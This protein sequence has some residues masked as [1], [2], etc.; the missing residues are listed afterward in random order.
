MRNRRINLFRGMSIVFAIMA[1]WSL[2]SICLAA[3][4]TGKTL[5]YKYSGDV[6][7]ANRKSGVTVLDGHAWFR[8][9]DGD[10]LNADKITM[11]RDVE[12]NEIIRIESVGNVEMKEKGMESTCQQSVF[13]EA[14]GRI[15]LKG[16]V[17]APAII[18]DGE[19]R[20]EALFI[21]YY[22]KEDRIFAS[23][24]LFSVGMD[25]QSDLDNGA[26]SEGLRQDF[27]NNNISLSADATVS[28]EESGIGWSITDGGKTYVI[29]KEE[30]KLSI[31][32]SDGVKGHVKVAVKETEPTEEETEK[33]EE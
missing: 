3:N 9:S 7:T 31:F 32:A 6:V 26:I 30:D 10:Y 19:N 1:I 29:R 33:K 2:R 28:K 11:Y 14:E 12:T 17:G 20:I 18:D 13:Y 5:T 25:A 22:R 27:K 8:R 23:G 4:E 21:T 16:V 24:L 15:E